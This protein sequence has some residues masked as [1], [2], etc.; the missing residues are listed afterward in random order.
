MK[1]A[2]KKTAAI[3]MII[4][5]TLFCGCETARLPGS[6]EA[7]HV[8]PLNPFMLY[9][10]NQSLE[11]SPID[12]LVEID[13][14]VVVQDEFEV[15]RQMNWKIFKL[16][17]SPGKH[18]IA[19]SSK[20]GEAKLAQEF[21]ITREHGASVQY[22]YYP[23]SHRFATPRHF[24]FTLLTDPAPGVGVFPGPARSGSP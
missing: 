11:I 12:I 9:V 17:L 19:V 14:E 21:T 5:T 10:C 24:R 16:M 2:M 4:T 13:G 18:T 1:N 20:K 6:A 15:S 7:E 22:W 8:A 3:V 23:E